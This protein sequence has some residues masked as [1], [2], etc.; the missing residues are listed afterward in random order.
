MIQTLRLIWR[1]PALRLSA[2][3]FF[4]VG[5]GAASMVPFQS[6]IAV[7]V[8]GLSDAGYALVLICDAVLGVAGAVTAGVLTDSRLDRRTLAIGAAALG[9][10]G[11]ALVWAAP[12][13]PAFF[14][15]HAV[16]YP[17]GGA[18]VAQLFALTRLASA[19]LPQAGRDA[20]VS[21][22]R[23][24][25]AIPFIVVLPVWSAVLTQGVPLLTIYPVVLGLQLGLMWI[26]VRAWPADGAADWSLPKSALPF[27]AGLREVTRPDILR[28]VA[29]MG[30]LTAGLPMYLAVLGL[31]FETEAARSRSDTALFFALVAGLE[32]PVMFGMG[33]LLARLSRDRLIAIGALLYGLFL[34]LLPVLVASP[35]VWWLVLPAAAG[36]GI[37]LTLPLAY[38]QD[39]LS[40]RPGAGGALIAVQRVVATAIAAVIFALGTALGGYGV[41][42]GLAAAGM[43]LAVAWFL[44]MARA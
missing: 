5:A 20:V 1:V 17:L 44:R 34:G 29:A 41:A 25:L 33:W 24:F 39:S 42:S 15:A 14:V 37:I 28:R 12:S 6:V 35:L 19:G 22:V 36:G 38:L 18:L 10:L 16:L 27:R 31:A 4:M 30:A 9:P 2:L 43:A 21:A 13:V 11:S 26:V 7:E 3:G 40:D 8:L 32:L 23:A